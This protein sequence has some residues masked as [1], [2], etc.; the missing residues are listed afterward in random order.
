MACIIA[1][2]AVTGS[3]V[4]KLQDATDGSGTGAADLAGATTAS[5]ST[6]NSAAKIV[7]KAGANRGFIRVVATV[8]TG[9]VFASAAMAGH[10]GIV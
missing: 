8:T 7:A 2:G 6:A 3:V 10:P 1:L 4:V 5:L 9:P